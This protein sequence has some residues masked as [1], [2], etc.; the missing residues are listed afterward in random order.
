MTTEI[1]IVYD[2]QC[3]EAWNCHNCGAKRVQIAAYFEDKRE[4]DQ[5]AGMAICKKCVDAASNIMKTKEKQL[6]QMEAMFEKFDIMQRGKYISLW[7]DAGHLPVMGEGGWY[8]DIF[9]PPGD[10][11]LDDMQGYKCRK[12]GFWDEFLVGDKGQNIKPCTG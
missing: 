7:L 6:R 4:P 12:C 3:G 2:M 1:D 9:P 8:A 11:N 10:E 5:Y